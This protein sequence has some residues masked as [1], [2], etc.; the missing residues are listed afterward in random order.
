[1]LRAMDMDIPVTL[2]IKAPNQ[3]YDDQTIYCFLNWTVEKLKTHIS[4]VYPSKPSSKDQR[5]V[6][7]GKL[8][9]DDLQ[10]KDVLRKS[11]ESTS[12]AA[13]LS[14]V[15]GPHTGGQ[16][17][18]GHLINTAAHPAFAQGHWLQ[19]PQAASPP[20][21]TTAPISPMSLLW[22]QQA[23]AWQL[24]MH[25]QASLAAYYQTATPIPPTGQS[26]QPRVEQQAAPADPIGGEGQDGEDQNRDWLDWVY[27]GARA[28]VL[29]SI[30]Y[31]Y[32]SFNRFVMVIGGML[33]LY[34]HQAGWLPFNLEHE[35]QNLADGGNQDELDGDLNDLQDMERVIDDGFGDEDGDSAEEGSEGPPG[36]DDQNGFFSSAWSFITTFF[37]SLIPEGVPNAAN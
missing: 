21:G 37:T 19:F 13:G 14:H 36:E 20:Y 30:I 25:Q 17:Q 7:S 6:Y 18:Q 27:T 4:H 33:L 15:P 31:F 1:M 11:T 3:K 35:L 34:L 16:N 9:S 32:S 24:Y 10:L 8:L 28:I 26:E 12:T 29:L 5:L 2:V 23:Y 22:W